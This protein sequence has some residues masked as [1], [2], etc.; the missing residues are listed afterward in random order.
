MIEISGNLPS[1]PNWWLAY[2]DHAIT[3]FSQPINKTAI[4]LQ[5]HAVSETIASKTASKSG[6]EINWIISWLSTCWQAV[7]KSIYFGFTFSSLF[8]QPINKTGIFLQLRAVS[9]NNCIQNWLKKW[10]QN[11]LDYIMAE[12]MLV[13][14]KEIILFWVHFLITFFRNKPSKS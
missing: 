7:R 12:H 3:F 9:R 14:C 2:E 8:S 5:L 11:K 13:S 6:P 4:F 10:T 1:R